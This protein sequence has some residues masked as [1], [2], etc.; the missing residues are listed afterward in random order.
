MTD[1]NR[2]EVVVGSN[3]SAYRVVFWRGTD[4]ETQWRLGPGRI[5]L[6]RLHTTTETTRALIPAA[7]EN[8]TELG[9]DVSEFRPVLCKICEDSMPAISC[10]KLPCDHHCCQDCLLDW[11]QNIICNAARCPPECCDG[12]RIDDNEVLAH[13]RPDVVHDFEDKKIE[14]STTDRTFCSEPACQRFIRPEFVSTELATCQRC[15]TLTCSKCK[16]GRHNGECPKDEALAQAI[17]T[18][19][20]NGGKRCP[21]CG[22]GIERSSGCYLMT[23]ISPTFTFC[24]AANFSSCNCKAEFCS[25]CGARWKTCD[26]GKFEGELYYGQFEAGLNLADWGQGQPD[27]DWGQ[28]LPFAQLEEAL[29]LPAPA[30][31]AERVAVPRYMD[32]IVDAADRRRR[33]AICHHPWYDRIDLAG[34][35]R[36]C[37]DCNTW[38]DYSIW[39]CVRCHV[40]RCRGC[41]GF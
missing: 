17:D 3:Q 19:E 1:G 18:L 21:G 36:G 22:E 24:S 40:Q 26:C 11:F 33:Q 31:R 41:A 9:Q 14:L 37:P 27:E 12:I 35:G 8:A 15:G 20:Q 39:E 16:R 10:V 23:Q 29:P 13:L 30:P 5:L 4:R 25:Q 2:A 6:E 34:L 7:D 38:F 28:G 32:N